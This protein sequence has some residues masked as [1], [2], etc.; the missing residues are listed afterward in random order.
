VVD[1]SVNLMQDD[2]NVEHHGYD[3]LD[4]PGMH[5]KA[6]TFKMRATLQNVG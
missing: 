6:W 3:L 1:D 4:E 2:T 5:K